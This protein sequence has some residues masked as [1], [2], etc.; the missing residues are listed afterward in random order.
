MTGLAI[1]CRLFDTYVVDALV[2]LVGQVPRM[3]GLLCRPL[4][5]GLV[6]FY[7]ILMV[8]GVAGFLLAVQ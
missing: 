3:V 2:D 7:A 6:Q 1:F 5:N 8:L 4:Q